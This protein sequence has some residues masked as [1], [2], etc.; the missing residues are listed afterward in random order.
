MTLVEV[1]IKYN[2]ILFYI[3]L[4]KYM[5]KRTVSDLDR[6]GDMDILEDIP[7]LPSIN[8]LQQRLESVSNQLDSLLSAMDKL[9]NVLN[10]LEEKDLIILGMKYI[11]GK[12]NHQVA[13]CTGYIS[14]YVRLRHTIL[15][16]FIDL[17]GKVNNL[18]I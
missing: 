4:L 7:P 12:S 13:E 18:N 3:E 14:N 9:S 6:R 8:E 15:M 10:I 16:E 17:I 5:L 1:L 11:A 2:A